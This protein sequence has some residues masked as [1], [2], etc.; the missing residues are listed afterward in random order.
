MTETDLRTV[1][2]TIRIEARPE[3]VWRYWTDP[4]LLREWWG[5]A[6]G[7]DPQPGGS[8]RVAMDHGPVVG[9]EFVELVPHERIVFS[10]GWEPHDGVPAMA[11]GSTRVEVTLVADGPDTVLTL[12][13]SDIPPA[14]A[15]E[16]GEGWAYHLGLLAAGAANS[17]G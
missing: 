17:N 11:Y 3:T 10:F 14:Y 15:G 12:R 6:T 2:Q 9:G 5:N 13:H 8:F 7:T 16:H 4:D 1:E